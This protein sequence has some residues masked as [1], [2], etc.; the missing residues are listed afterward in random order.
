[1]AHGEW[2]GGARYMIRVASY[3]DSWHG[4]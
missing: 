3:Y 2:E 1:V 4:S